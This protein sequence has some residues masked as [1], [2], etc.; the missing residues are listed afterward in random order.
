MKESD[1]SVQTCR[2]TQ[3]YAY[4]IVGAKYCWKWVGDKPTI[5]NRWRGRWMEWAEDLCFASHQGSSENS[6]RSNVAS[7]KFYYIVFYKRRRNIVK[8]KKS[9]ISFFNSN[10]EQG[11]YAKARKKTTYKILPLKEAYSGIFTLN[12][13]TDLYGSQSEIWKMFWHSKKTNTVRIC[14]KYEEE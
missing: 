10:M 14:V 3:L 6:V 11:S 8:T 5:G 13:E 7:K 9:F 4:T 1:S 2:R 12:L